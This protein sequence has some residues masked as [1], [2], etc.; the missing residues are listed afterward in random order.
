MDSEAFTNNVLYDKVM[1]I[2]LCLGVIYSGLECHIFIPTLCI[3]V[4]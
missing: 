4:F 3:R 1:V 2:F